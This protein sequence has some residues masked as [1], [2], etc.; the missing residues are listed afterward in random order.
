MSTGARVFK[1]KF[2]VVGGGGCMLYCRLFVR[3]VIGPSFFVSFR[4]GLISG[5]LVVVCWWWC[6]C[7]VSYYIL[8]GSYL[9]WF[10]NTW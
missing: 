2:P 10:L 3:Y 7:R 4:V 6:A 8:R 5:L 1:S 9:L